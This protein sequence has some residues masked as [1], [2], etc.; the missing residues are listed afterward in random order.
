MDKPNFIEEEED[1]FKLIPSDELLRWHYKL[2]H[3]PFKLMQQMATKE[4]Y[5]NAWQP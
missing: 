1:P 3:T 4:I 2:R 5:Q